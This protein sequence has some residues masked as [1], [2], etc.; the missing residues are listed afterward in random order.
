MTDKN[1]NT[2]PNTDSARPVIEQLWRRARINAFAHRA[3][4]REAS[5]AA[6][7]YFRWEIIAT[8]G[9]ILFVILVYVSTSAN[10]TGLWKYSGVAFT[11]LSIVGTLAA[12]YCSVMAN[13]LKFDVR[14]AEHRHLLNRYQHVAQRA[15]EV[16]WPDLPAFKVNALLEDLER[17][18]QL[19][20]ATGTEPEDRHFDVAHA[21]VKKIREN[22]EGRI[23]QSFELEIEPAAGPRGGEAELGGRAEN[24]SVVEQK[25]PGRLP[26]AEKGQPGEGAIPEKEPEN[27]PERI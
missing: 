23:A 1:D 14:A 25:E 18:F 2:G 13:Y 11:L 20:K 7:R 10:A 16:K 27:G 24:E 4:L 19:L 26:D 3:A 8:L 5:D 15:R 9:S 21:L 17:D 12:L 22:S 6:E